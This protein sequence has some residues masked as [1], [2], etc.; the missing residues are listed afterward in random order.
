[1]YLLNS[2]VCTFGIVL[3]SAIPISFECSA[4]AL[5]HVGWVDPNGVLWRE[6]PFLKPLG[7]DGRSGRISR[8]GNKT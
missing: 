2:V 6:G 8:P 3:N 4:A 5:S 1:M 7:N